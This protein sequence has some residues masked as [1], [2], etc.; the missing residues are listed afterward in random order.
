MIAA[1][2]CLIPASL[3]VDQPWTLSPSL[4]SVLA[5]I[6]LSVFC[7]GIALL[8]YFRLVNTLGSLGVASQAYLRV[9]I[10]VMLGVV[11]LGESVT[12][13]MGVGLVAAVCGVAMINF[14]GQ[15]K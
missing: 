5:T 15:K 6:T 12:S 7:T 1:A 13:V 9:G 8:L 3:I 4:L 14:F 10:G 2:V 11:V